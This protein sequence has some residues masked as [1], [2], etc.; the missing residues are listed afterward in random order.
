HQEKYSDV[1]I[2]PTNVYFYGQEPGQEVAIEIERG[3]T[4][5]VRFLNVG[6]PHPDG[7]R[8]VFFELNGQPRSINVRDLSLEPEEK[9]RIKANQSDPQQVCAPL[10]ALVVT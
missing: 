5:I 3:K 10:S 1:S 8:T 2:L 7:R 6:A 9:T 4:L